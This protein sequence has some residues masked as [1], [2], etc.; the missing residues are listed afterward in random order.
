MLQEC[1]TLT[2]LEDAIKV[3]CPGKPEPYLKGLL[4]CAVHVASDS[5]NTI[6]IIKLMSK[7][8]QLDYIILCN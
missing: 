7:V 5:N 3:V 2:V 1:V 8:R 4:Q 6:N